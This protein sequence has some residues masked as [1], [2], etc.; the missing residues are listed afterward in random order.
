MAWG[1]FGKLVE[2]ALTT[3][4]AI[5]VVRTLAPRGF[6]TY[7][8][9]TN[10]AGS[11]SVFIPVVGT[12]ALGAV[13][14]RFADRRQRVWLVG[15]IVALRLTV[16]LV[17]AA[18]V[19][20]AWSYLGN[21]FGLGYVS[22]R[23]LAVGVLYW[24]AQD[25]LNTVGGLYLSELN[26]RP[27]ALWRAGGQAFTLTGVAI[28]A[29]LGEAT[30][31]V[32]LSIVSAGY[33]LAAFRL[34]IAL[35]RNGATRVPRERVRFVL[36]FTPHVWVIGIVSFAQATQIDVLLIGAFTH[37]VGEVAFYVA[38]VGVVGRAQLVLVGGWGSLII[39]TLGAALQAGGMRALARAA[40]LFGELLLL[41]MLPLNA[42]VLA[43]AYPLVRALFGASY[44]RAGDLL[45]VFAAAT[46]V[47]TPAISSAAVSALWAIDRQ[48]LLARVRV[49][50]AALNVVLAVVLI[51][52]YAGMGA[53]IATGS[54]FILS[55]FVEVVLAQRA[56]AL[57]Y[58]FAVLFRAAPA[59][60]AGAGVAWLIPGGGVNV[61]LALLA[62]LATYIGVLAILRPLTAEH[63]ELLGRISPRLTSWP[64]RLLVRA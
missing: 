46:V 62:G 25:L 44:Q 63:V 59:A 2:V 35:V 19:M 39:P 29:A 52:R 30:V 22:L 40:R 11:A 10:L 8:L 7:A 32:V 15:L 23:V 5:V 43:T 4:V 57:D 53:V 45:V 16:I 20:S 28:A 18:V 24:A 48:R 58:P 51:P 3:V 56:G 50:V 33:A 13:L 34:G 14:P 36:G 26:L 54:A 9:L 27:I 21:T 31:G 60:A 12:E 1:Q 37:N 42:L 17:V 55:S 49:V 47:A 38:A 6:G 64:L 41:V 61:A